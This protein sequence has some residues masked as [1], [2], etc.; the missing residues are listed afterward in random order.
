MREVDRIAD[1]LRRAMSGPAWHGPSLTELLADVG[2]ETAAARPLEGR[3][4]IW[5]L[6]LHITAWR[7]VVRDRLAGHA[8]D[9]PREGDW[10][11]VPAPSAAAWQHALSTLRESAD[12]LIRAVEALDDAELDR[13]L[14]PS[15][16]TIYGNLHGVVQHDLY[17][18]GQIGLLKLVLAPR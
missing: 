6:V 10:P 12:R 16:D 18:G 15:R 4:T 14:P 8:L 7:N 2:A 3:H 1:Q 11:A 9:N 13:E 5:E 17:H